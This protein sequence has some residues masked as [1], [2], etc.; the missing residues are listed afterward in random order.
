[1]ADLT[2]RLDRLGSIFGAELAERVRELKT[3]LEQLKQGSAEGTAAA[4]A[5]RLHGLKGAARAADAGA[6]EQVVHAAE[7]ATLALDGR[8]GIA[9]F[10]TVRE[11]LAALMMLH[12]DPGADASAVLARLSSVSRRAATKVSATPER[13]LPERAEQ[14]ASVR[15]SLSK[16]DTLLTESG[17]LSVTQLRIGERVSQLRDLQRQLERLQHDWSKTRPAR[18][19]LR[20]AGQ[21]TTRESEALLRAADQAD[22]TVQGVLQRTREL[23]NGL[24]Q[25]ASQLATVAAAIGQEVMAI[26]LMPAGTIFLPLERLV[27]DL[28]RQTG[29]AARLELSGSDTEVDRRILDELRDPLMHMVRNSLDHGLES[30]D[31]RRL[32]GK[33][34][35]GCLRLSAVQRGDRIEIVVEDDGRGLDIEAI[36]A[37]AIRRNL[38]TLERAEQ[39][40]TAALIDL[41]FHPGFSTRD[42]VSELSGRGVGMDVVRDHISRLGGDIRV[43]TT[44]GLGTTFTLTVPLTLATTRVLLVEDQGHTYAVPTSNVERTGRVRGRELHHLEGRLGLQIDGRVVPVVELSGVLQRPRKVTPAGSPDDWRPFFVLSQSDSAVA[45]LTDR[46]VDETEL[47]VKSLGAPLKRVRH[48]AG[49]A[50]LGTGAM[51]V[52]LNPADLFKSSLGNVDNLE[53]LAPPGAATNVERM[54][55]RRVLVVDD[56]VMTRTLQRTILESAGYSVIVASDGAHALELLDDSTEVDAIVSDVEMP[57]MGGF[58]LIAALRQNARLRHLP[59]IL[60]TSLDAPEHIERGAAAGADAYIV[61][62]RFDQ[63]DLLQ[64]VGR[65]V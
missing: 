51:A 3:L 65:L 10:E 55:R 32:A 28:A 8:P 14:S 12:T 38:L 33:P 2:A 37:T 48:V 18:A 44:P 17:E 31:E 47:V 26:R 52:V 6:I 15:V 4:I 54:P 24:A 57:G 21:R 20:R 22:R 19:R 42:V 13:P 7:A 45:L 23:A 62:G 46:L 30:A 11:A 56:S 61:K 53:R 34:A 50:V 25:N 16:L 64:A 36:R 40:D 35:Q 49:A 39:I 43:Y 58:E 59:V 63:K 9:W 1:V 5:R 60:V 29:K 27:R 41:I